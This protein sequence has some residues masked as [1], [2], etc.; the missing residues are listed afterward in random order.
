MS[1]EVVFKE[2]CYNPRHTGTYCQPNY[3][4]NTQTE[5]K[6]NITHDYKVWYMLVIMLY[7]RTETIL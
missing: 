3:T 2:T 5:P 4:S 7:D 6:Y 1:S